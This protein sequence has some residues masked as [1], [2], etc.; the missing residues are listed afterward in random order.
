LEASPKIE[1]TQLYVAVVGA[2]LLPSA[3]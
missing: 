3:S 2:Q 1:P